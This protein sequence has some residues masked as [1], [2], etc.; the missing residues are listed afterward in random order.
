M[1]GSGS[2]VSGLM[3]WL[4][5]GMMHH[6]DQ[7]STNHLQIWEREDDRKLLQACL[8]YLIGQLV[9]MTGKGKEWR[10]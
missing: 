1:F 9:L 5:P 2:V 8:Y 6:L 3:W 7:T 10:D 4:E